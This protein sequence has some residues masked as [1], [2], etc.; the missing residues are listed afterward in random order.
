MI[1]YSKNF[2]IIKKDL[3]DGFVKKH[4]YKT[5]VEYWCYKAKKSHI[6]KLDGSKA[7][8]RNIDDAELSCIIICDDHFKEDKENTWLIKGYRFD[9][10][11]LQDYLAKTG[12][13]KNG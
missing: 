7:K 1:R 8:L 2:V 5:I 3:K 10:Q 12:R 13:G 9:G 6:F 11:D 4:V